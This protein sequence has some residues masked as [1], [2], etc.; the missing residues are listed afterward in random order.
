MTRTSTSRFAGPRAALGWAVPILFATAASAG[1]DLLSITA[2]LVPTSGAAGISVNS[3]QGAPTA[4]GQ[5]LNIGIPGA[6]ET[7]TYGVVAKPG[8][9]GSLT[10]VAALAPGANIVASGNAIADMALGDLK[11]VDPGLAAGTLVNYTINFQIDGKIVVTAFGASSA[12][13]N[14]ELDYGTSPGSLMTIGTAFASTNGGSGDSG[15]FS[16]GTEGVQTHSPVETGFVG[17][18]VFAEFSLATHAGADAGPTPQ[19][20]GQASA[21][22]DFLD[23]FSFPTN[24][25]VFNFFDAKG[26]PLTGVTV[27][28]GD[29]CIVNNRFVCGGGAGGGGTGVPEPA[30]WTMLLLGFAGLGYAGGV[31]RRGGATY[32]WT[33]PLA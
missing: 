24:G 15:I 8:D 17:H 1:D 32:A 2:N 22:A 4:S 18:D 19:E 7:L 27:D 33:A 13:A 25:P 20:Q 6:A 30:T 9:L 28:S 29:G 5:T 21:S 23:P 26:N 16:G 11:I 14:V 3:S 10:S 12:N 31:R